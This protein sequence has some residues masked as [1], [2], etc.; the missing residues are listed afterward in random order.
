M[1]NRKETLLTRA[2]VVG[3]TQ[4]L[5][6]RQFLLTNLDRASPSDPYHFRIP[7]PFLQNAIDEIGAFPYTPGERV[8]EK[9]SLFLKGENETPFFSS[10]LGIFVAIRKESG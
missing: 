10:R 6:V 4:D 5:G 9:P 8:Y 2:V 7:L 3:S 1:G